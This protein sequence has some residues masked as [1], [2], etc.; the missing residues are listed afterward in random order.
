M[1]HSPTDYVLAPSS[2]GVSFALPL[3]RLGGGVTVGVLA[4]V[5]PRKILPGPL[6]PGFLVGRYVDR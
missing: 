6:T 1:A 5:V 2:T 4:C 3:F